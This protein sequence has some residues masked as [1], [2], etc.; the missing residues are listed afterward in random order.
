[1]FISLVFN[2]SLGLI[3]I[4]VNNYFGSR[5]SGLG[6]LS[7]YDVSKIPSE[8]GFNFLFR[9]LGPS[10]FISICSIFLYK[11]DLDLLVD[12]IYF[13]VI[14]YVVINFVIITFLDRWCFVNKLTYVL[15]QLGM[16]LTAYYFYILSLSR[17]LEYILP[18]PGNFR[19]ELWF[20]VILYFYG[21]SQNYRSGDDSFE[22]RRIVVREKYKFLKNKYTY[23]LS[24]K[25]LDD[26]VLRMK[27]FSIMIAEDINRPRF[28]RVI[29]KLFFPL[30]L[31]KTSGIMQ[32]KSVEYLSD[33]QSIKIAE[34]KVL[35]SFNK[36][37]STSPFEIIVA[38][39]KDYNGG[40]YKDLIIS[41]YRDISD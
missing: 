24:G 27:F 38:V 9:V 36:T 23:L 10:V 8:S 33:E 5:S 7:Y 29:E 40:L 28:V 13:A 16:I 32:V 18:E 4:L 41:I 20:I 37:I 21:L 31:V 17:G 19:T 25:L 15:T 30:H 6:Y 3:F 1:M 39:C 12:N 14:F 35:E 26:D 11:L 22:R 34:K 2:F